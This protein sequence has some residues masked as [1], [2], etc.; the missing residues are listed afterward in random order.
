MKPTLSP[1]ELQRVIVRCGGLWS[2]SDLAK[3]AGE[4]ARRW[5]KRGDFPAA[6][7]RTGQTKLYAG[8]HV[9]HWMEK[10]GHHAA[11]SELYEI[12]V[13]MRTKKQV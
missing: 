10:H 1:T 2:P 4:G 12:M 5:N 7:W 11:A 8:W 6:S 13:R 9:W 3:L